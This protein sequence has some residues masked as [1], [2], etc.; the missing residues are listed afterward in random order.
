MSYS[1]ITSAL[2]SSEQSRSTHTDP[3]TWSLFPRVRMSA[4][5]RWRRRVAFSNRPHEETHRHQTGMQLLC[6]HLKS[7]CFRYWMLCGAC[8]DVHCSSSNQKQSKYC[9]HTSFVFPR[10]TSV[11]T[12]R[13]SE[14]LLKLRVLILRN[15]SVCSP[16]HARIQDRHSI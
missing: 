14:Y 15:D 11:R 9:E 13:F 1:R 5:T 4:I 10:S 7:P 6:T 3:T 2:A 8:N 12:F 16:F